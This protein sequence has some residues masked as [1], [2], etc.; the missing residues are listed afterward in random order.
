MPDNRKPSLDA[1]ASRGV[2]IGCALGAV[3]WMVIGLL[4]WLL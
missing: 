4:A 3:F 2:V 1:T